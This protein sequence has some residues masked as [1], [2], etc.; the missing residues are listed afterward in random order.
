MCFKYVTLIL[1]PLCPQPRQHL[2]RGNRQ[3]RDAHAHGVKDGVG[4][5]AGYGDVAAFSDAFAFV[6]RGA[7]V[8]LDEDSFQYRDIGGG[9]VIELFTLAR[10]TLCRL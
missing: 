9:G 4:Y 3:V 10:T 7:G 6:G 2:V 8:A 1:T 5:G